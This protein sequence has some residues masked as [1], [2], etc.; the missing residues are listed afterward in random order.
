LERRQTWLVVGLILGLAAGLAGGWSFWGGR[1]RAAADRLA[2]LESSAVQIQ[3]ERERLH[4]E[5]TDIVRE[6]REMAATAEHLRAQV[7]K[8]LRR[9]ESLASELAPPAPPADAPED[10]VPDLPPADAP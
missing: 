5:L 4:S 8:Q 6:R 3:T 7:D 10:S 2:A 9:L 1:A